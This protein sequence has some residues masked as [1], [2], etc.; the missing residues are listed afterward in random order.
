MVFTVKHWR[1]TKSGGYAVTDERDIYEVTANFASRRVRACLEAVVD[2]DVIQTAVEECRRTLR[3]QNTEPLVDRV[4]KMVSA[5]GEIGVNA[6]MIQDRL[7]NKLEAVSENQLAL[8]RRIYKSIKDGV[9]DVKD[10]FSGAGI[11]TQ[12]PPAE[13]QPLP[14]PKKGAGKEAEKPEADDGL[15]PVESQAA[16][17]IAGPQAELQKLVA[18]AGF[19]LTIF[20]RWGEETGNVP[21]GTSLTSFAEVPADITKRLLRASKGLLDGLKRTSGK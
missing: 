18:D 17:A 7:G 14:K 19:D 20:G 11:T 1:D 21:N 12:T 5:F 3:G 8:L 2:G 10:F 4:R 13:K 9:G 15:G 16:A 6:G